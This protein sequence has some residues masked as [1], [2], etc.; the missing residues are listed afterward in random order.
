[1]PASSPAAGPGLYLGK[2]T[3]SIHAERP[4][5]GRGVR[6]ALQRTAQGLLWDSAAGRRQTHRVV[7]C[8]RSVLSETVTVHRQAD[9]QGARFGGLLMCGSGWTCPVCCMRIAEARRQELSAGL[10]WHIKTGGHVHLMTLTTP[11][12]VDMPLAELLGRL[13]KAR[14]SF[15]NSRTYKRISLAVERHGNAASLECTYGRLNGWHPHLH[16]LLFVSRPLDDKQAAE[17]KS[18]WVHALLRAGLGDKSKLSDMLERALDLRGGQDAADYVTK[19]GREETW[20]ISSELT[21]QH[22]K[23]SRGEHLTPFGL[24]AVALEA[25]GAWAGERFREFAEAMQ[26]KRLMTYSP[27]LRAALNLG[28][29]LTDSQLVEAPLPEEHQVA[30]ISAEQWKIVLRADARAELLEYVASM[31]VDPDTGQQDVDDF[32]EHLGRRRARGSP[33]FSAYTRDGGRLGISA[34]AA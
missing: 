4:K 22:T 3:K 2:N 21:R 32:I 12:T 23:D 30:R 9:G 15:K 31:C 24:L 16:E 29:E 5:S 14:A 33:Y 18:A 25:E 6:Y 8:C 1:M 7:H 26:G 27:G 20:G 34:R 13:D 17:L 19:Y 11:H 10:V 28:V